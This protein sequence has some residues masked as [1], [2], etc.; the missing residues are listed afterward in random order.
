MKNT[1]GAHVLMGIVSTSL[2]HN[3][4]EQDLTVFTSVASL[5]PW[6]EETI[7]ENGGM[8]SCNFNISALPVLGTMPPRSVKSQPFHFERIADPLQGKQK[9]LHIFALQELRWSLNLFLAY[10]SS[11]ADRQQDNSRQL[12]RSVLKI[13][14]CRPFLRHVIVLGLSSHK[15]SLLN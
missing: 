4:N 11:V 3:C 2:G 8:A 1:E 12:K 7:K 10:S 9:N 13:A 14:Q 15:P 5:L 6:I